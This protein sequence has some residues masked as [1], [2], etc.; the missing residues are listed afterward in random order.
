MPGAKN[1]SDWKDRQ[2]TLSKKSPHDGIDNDEQ[3]GWMD[4]Y[5]RVL[6]GL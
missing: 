2:L 1:R 6:K 5:P 3:D 4:G